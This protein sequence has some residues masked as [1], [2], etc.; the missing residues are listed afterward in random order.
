MS[1]KILLTA[2]WKAL[3]PRCSESAAPILA[4]PQGETG[5]LQKALSILP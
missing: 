5:T 4:L 1:P 2:E 3:S